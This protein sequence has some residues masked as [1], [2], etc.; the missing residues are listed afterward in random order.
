MN[1]NNDNNNKILIKIQ[2]VRQKPNYLVDTYITLTDCHRTLSHRFVFENANI[3][4][5]YAYSIVS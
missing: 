3:D 4:A 5:E 2:T 1:K